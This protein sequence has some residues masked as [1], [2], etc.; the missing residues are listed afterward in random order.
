M[1]VSQVIARWIFILCLPVL[2]LSA[3][4]AWGFNSQWIFGY[5]FQKY[6]VSQITGLSENELG[7]IGKSWTEY[8]NSSD[9]YWHITITKDG[10]TFELFTPDEQVHFKDVK[11]LI[12]LDYRVLLVTGIIVLGYALVS[13]FWRR[14]RYWRQLARSVIWGSGL[15]IALI[16]ILGI[17][18]MLDFDQLFLQLH[19]LIFTNSLWSAQG[20]MLLLFPG[21]FWFDAALFCIGFMAGLAIV[22]GSSAVIYLKLTGNKSVSR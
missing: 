1:R 5:G 3:S 21:G 16:I 12:W 7:K 19:Y 17:G 8:I 6:G 4:I 22:L 10:K 14:G 15:A 2:L 9:E 18:S 20:Y 13:I 11:Q